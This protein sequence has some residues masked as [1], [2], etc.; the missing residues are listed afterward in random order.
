MCN[1]YSM[2]RNR[3]A[4]IRL[5]RVS[6]NRAAAFKPQSAI[7]PGN[8]APIIRMTQ[9]GERELVTMSW[10]FPLHQKDKAAKRVTNAR[11]D[12]VLKSRFWRSSFEE[13]R[14]LVPVT[15][16]SEPKGLRPAVWHW[17]ALDEMREPF[18]FAGLWRHWKGRLKPRADPV[19]MDVFAFLTT[20]PNAIVA[21][22]HPTRMPVML[23]G[24][25][26]QETWLD[27]TA[28]E[29][30]ALARPYPAEDMKIV[31]SGSER[32]DLLDAA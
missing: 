9:D 27:G 29:A 12:T 3:E 32:K 31:R 28:D 26:A 14:C 8:T 17:Y 16:F 18:A 11:E 15:S 30:I 1:L 2:T 20:P 22:I 24:E 6:H 4:I 10:G 19:E 7:F 25:K 13:R 23:V 21:P 5:F